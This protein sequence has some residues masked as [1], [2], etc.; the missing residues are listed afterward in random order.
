MPAYSRSPGN[1]LQRRYED[2]AAIAGEL[3]AADVPERHEFDELVQLLTARPF[4]GVSLT[5]AAR[6]SIGLRTRN[7]VE[8][9]RHDELWSIERHGAGE[10]EHVNAAAF[11]ASKEKAPGLLQTDEG[12]REGSHGNRTTPQEQLSLFGGESHGQL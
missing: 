5:K 10:A 9:A 8:R 12:Q 7:D 1:V 6:L 11:A 3:V 4:T 2:G